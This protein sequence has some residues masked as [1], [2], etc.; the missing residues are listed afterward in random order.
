MISKW[1]LIAFAGVLVWLSCLYHW[2]YM[3]LQEEIM[4]EAQMQEVV[5]KINALS[6]QVSKLE[7]YLK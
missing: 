4:R 1:N 2:N 5:E 6:E 3:K 7:S